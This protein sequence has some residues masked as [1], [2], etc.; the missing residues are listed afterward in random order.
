MVGN[1]ILRWVTY[2]NR[3]LNPHCKWGDVSTGM[4]SVGDNEMLTFKVASIAKGVC[5][6]TQMIAFGP[7]TCPYSH[8]QFC[9]FAL[10]LT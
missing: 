7:I 3:K 9:M 2:L 1:V 6:L 5:S 4:F 10:F 8:K